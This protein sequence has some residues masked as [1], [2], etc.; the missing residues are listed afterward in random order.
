MRPAWS[1]CALLLWIS[2]F[3][4]FYP[5]YA[6]TTGFESFVNVFIILIIKVVMQFIIMS[7][8]ISPDLIIFFVFFLLLLRVPPPKPFWSSLVFFQALA[9]YL[10]PLGIAHVAELIDAHPIWPVPMRLCLEVILGECVEPRHQVLFRRVLLLV[11]GD[12]LNEGLLYLRVG[13]A[14]VLEKSKLKWLEFRRWQSKQ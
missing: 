12:K 2:H 4:F 3:A 5:V 7:T 11:T 8:V 6:F 9:I 13:I 14:C 10:D 1:T